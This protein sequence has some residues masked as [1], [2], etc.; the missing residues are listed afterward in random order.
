MFQRF[1]KGMDSLIE[2]TLHTKGDTN[3]ELRLRIIDN[4]IYWTL[5]TG[6]VPVRLPDT[7]SEFVSLVASSPSGVDDEHFDFLKKAGYSEDAILEILYA[8]ALGAGLARYSAL[9]NAYK[10][11]QNEISHP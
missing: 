11:L 2:A 9:L 5:G 6:E 7:I 8:A 3:T 10:S 1:K 4:V